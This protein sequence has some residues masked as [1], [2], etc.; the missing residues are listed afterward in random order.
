MM[1]KNSHPSFAVILSA[2]ASLVCATNCFCAQ[3]P[4]HGNL[5]AQE[6]GDAVYRQLGF[7]SSIGLDYNH[8]AIFAGLNSSDSK[9]TLEAKGEALLSSGDT[10]TEVALSEFN[11]PS[12]TYYGAYTVTYQAM[13]F[14]D[15]KSVVSTAK[16]IADA[17][18]P[19]VIFDAINFNSG[20]RSVNYISEIRCDAVVEYAY[21]ANGFIVWYPTAATGHW[22]ILS[23]PDDHNSAPLFGY[24]SY[25]FSP[26]AQ[27]GAPGSSDG[28]NTFMTK[29]SVINLPTYEV[30][31]VMG[32]G[33]VD[34]TVK[35]TDES[36]IHLIGYKKPGDASYSFSPTQPQHPTSD[37]YPYTVRVTTSGYFYYF[38]QDNG[39]NNPTSASYVL[40]TVPPSISVTVQPNPTDRAF[41][42]DGTT[43]ST[44]QT[45]NWVPSSPHTIATTAT[46]GESADARYIWSSW[47]DGGALSHTI[48]PA[49]SATYTANFTTQY[50]LTTSAGAGGTVSPSSGWKNSGAVIPI[51]AT[52]S[53]GYSFTSWT[54]SGS[55][56]YSG[57]SSSASVTMNGPVSE[58]ASFTIIPVVVSV[59]VRPNLPGRAFMVDG[60]PYTT[61]QTFSWTA[62]TS[63]SVETTSLQS[64]VAGVQY[65][66]SGWSDGGA[67]AHTI[68]PASSATYT[69]SFTT[70]YFLTMEAG[71]NGNVNLTNG[72]YNSGA[73]L[74]IIATANDGY[75]LG[76]WVGSGTG[77]YSGNKNSASITMSAPITE[78]ASFTQAVCSAVLLKPAPGITV[79]V[80]PKFMWTFAENCRHKIYLATNPIPDHIAA[81]TNTFTAGTNTLNVT[82]SQWSNVL[83]ELGAAPTYY[84]TVGAADTEQ[85]EPPLFAEWRSFSLPDGTL[86]ILEPPTSTTIAKGQTLSLHVIAA[87]SN[88]VGYQ[89]TFNGHIIPGAVSSTFTILGALPKNSGSYS[90]LV[91]DGVHPQTSASA[92]VSVING[93]KILGGPANRTVRAGRPVA[94][95]VTV[96]GTQPLTYQ[97]YFNGTPIPGATDR[98]VYFPSVQYSYRGLFS[99]RV[100]NPAGTVQSRPALLN[101]W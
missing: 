44:A 37:S 21:E 14:T 54:G 96:S 98:R 1:T 76:G 31:Q 60:T 49:S 56:A 50:Y 4:T 80:P 45:F 71:L 3:I 93:V 32:S 66:W 22:N 72:W 13:S 47:S 42:V 70:Q 68:T 25:E 85:P 48:Y 62:G 86:Q 2:L 100:T 63:H 40:I 69:A 52:P 58:S 77:S 81:L 74:P 43:Y 18:I 64:E 41:T 9:R 83:A 97:W 67:L 95:A 90:V 84:W 82:G 36:G 34:V 88:G 78:S 19:Y 94:F 23:Y 55:D 20:G 38:A 24:P 27:R 65:L 79:L 59:T 99:V 51:N 26:W 33:Y 92:T 11:G 87:S 91:H 16:S 53:L 89:W 28:G 35:A 73:V 57:N 10:T 6:Y 17:Y 15:R 61:A 12:Q 5:S 46:Q 30:T 7:W 8:T 29:P 39:G 75:N 101:V